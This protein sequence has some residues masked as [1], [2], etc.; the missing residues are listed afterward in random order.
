VHIGPGFIPINGRARRESVVCLVVSTP[1]TKIGNTCAESPE[2]GSR[3]LD[4]E[5]QRKWRKMMK[6]IE[7]SGS[8]VP[9]LRSLRKKGKSLPKDLV[10]GT[11]VRFK[12]LKRWKIIAEIIEWLRCQHWWVFSEMDF[13]MLISAYGKQGD[14]ERAERAVG[15]M[16]R[17]GFSLNVVTYTALIE[18]YGRA[19]HYK[20]AES[21]FKRMQSSGPEPSVLT[22]QTMI[23]V[24]VEGK[25]I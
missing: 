13:N 5:A 2:P 21:I 7:T 22:F 19:G 15:L 6:D 1:R 14:F 23:K 24:L 9:V 3:I 4:E 16:K 20:K 8:A 17:S 12:Q 25:K 18:A 11:L 10:L